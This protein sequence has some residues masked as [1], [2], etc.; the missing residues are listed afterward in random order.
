MTHPEPSNGGEGVS[1]WRVVAVVGVAT[2]LLSV[3]IWWLVQNS[4]LSDSTDSTLLETAATSTSSKS[5]TASTT[6][7]VAEVTTT[8]LA[9]TTTIS[10]GTTSTSGANTNTTSASDTPTTSPG[11]PT[12]TQPSTT[13]SP[14]TTTTTP[15]STT[16][17]TPPS[18]STQAPKTVT[19][20]IVNFA[21]NPNPITINVGDTVRWTNND[22]TSHTTTSSGSWDSG[23]LT[24]GAGFSVVFGSPGT[25]NYFCTIHGAG[26]MSATVVVNP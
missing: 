14:T 9:D 25:F 26:T 6:T 17:T 4:V 11:S 12:T 2:V 1:I 19:G 23:S 7:S 18:T 20:S 22:P 16:T 5:A 10:D 13:T 15:P 24:P 3:P 21:Y 8:E